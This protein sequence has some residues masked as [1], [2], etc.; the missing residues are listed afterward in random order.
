MSLA[1]LSAGVSVEQFFL[2][3]NWLGEK[4]VN[5]SS[6]EYTEFEDVFVPTLDFPVGKFFAHHNWQGV[7][8][9]LVSVSTGDTNE[10]QPLCL[11]MKVTDFFRGIQWQG[12]KAPQKTLHIAQSPKVEEAE[13]MSPPQEELNMSDLS[14]LF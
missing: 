3:A 6:N 11:T 9:R 1:Q 12:Q 10:Y 2:S 14:D 5:Q 4:R 8:Q 7:K 13:N